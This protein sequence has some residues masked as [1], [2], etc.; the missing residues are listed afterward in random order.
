MSE[1]PLGLAHLSALA[2][3]PPQLIRT[4][5]EIGYSSVGIRLVRVNAE[6]PGYP[7]MDRPELMRETL[8][9]LRETGIAVNDVEFVKFTPDID[10][11][12]L[13]PVVDAAAALGA[14]HIIAAPYDEH[15]ER[16]GDNLARFTEL[17]KRHGVG[18]ALEFFP[19]TPVR[20]LAACWRLVE[21]VSPDLAILVD[22]LHFDRS[23]SDPDLLKRL[24]ATRLPFAQFCDA[25]VLP[26]YSL[27][28]LL[29]AARAERLAPGSGEIPLR[30]ILSA[31]PEAIP[32]SLEVPQLAYTAA[33][34]ERQMLQRLFDDARSFFRV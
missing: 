19:W 26:E 15:A 29:L 5:A 1:R 9:A 12:A 32:I 13:A 33:V 7:L 22:T 20:D 3:A 14:R 24:P 34:G 18:V 2:L 11:A 16:L 31:L 4:A 21:A 17:A 28:T 30:P 23:G 25:R 6:T 10:T 27:E 8:A